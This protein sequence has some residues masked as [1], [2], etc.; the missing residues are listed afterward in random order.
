[1]D[2]LNLSIKELLKAYREKR[3]N[4]TEVCRFYLDRIETHDSELNAVLTRNEQALKE[5]RFKDDHFDKLKDK[6]LFGVPLLLKD[7][8]CTK[9]I[10]TTA[11]SRMLENYVPPF[12]AEVILRL[13]AAGAIILGKCNQDEFAMGNSGQNSAFSKTLNPWNKNHVPGGSSSGSATAVSAGFC[14]ASIG[15]DTGGSVR[16]PSAFCHLVGIKPTYGRLSRYGMVAYASS[17]DQAGVMAKNVEDTAYLLEQMAGYDVKDN[18]SAGREVPRWSDHLTADISRLKIGYLKGEVTK[19][20][21]APPE[22]SLYYDKDI[23]QKI[24]QTLKL[25]TKAGLQTK[26]ISLP[27]FPLSSSV[28]YLIST[29]EASSN[30][31]CYD[32][33]RYGSRWKMENEKSDPSN[34]SLEK[35]YSTTRSCGF[36]AEVKRRILMGTYCLSQG[37]YDKFYQKASQIRNLIRKEI[38]EQLSQVDVILSP[39]TSHA[40]FK[41]GENPSGSLHSYTGDSYTVLANLAGIPALSVPVGFSPEGLP[42][43][44]QLMAKHFDEQTLFNVAWFIEKALKISHKRPPV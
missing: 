10:R 32:G 18:S 33:I 5:A 16:Q 25:F 4:V 31:A 44:L 23:H 37:Y 26:E 43:G 2:F 28:Y 38:L 29:S 11:G 14:Q 34:T 27:L 30:L 8:F 15:T 13:E 17:L 3:C 7:M 36:G 12:S 20:G 21:V 24:E 22:G 6:P 42:I 1:M 40:A 35:F 39:V 19:D 41:V 9:G